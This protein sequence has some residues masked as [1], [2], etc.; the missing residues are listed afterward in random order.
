VRRLLLGDALP[1]HVAVVG[2]GD[3]GEDR[4][5]L[6]D[7]PHRH[8]VGRHTGAGGD[9]EETELGVDGIQ[10]TVGTEAHPGDVVAD[11]FGFPT[12]NGRLEHREVGLAALAREGAGDVVDLP[13]RG[14]QLEDEHVLGHPAVVAGH[15]R[16]DAQGVALLAEEGV[17]AVSA[18]VGPDFAGLGEVRDVLRFATGPLDVGLA[19]REW[20]A[21]GVQTLDE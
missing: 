10:P 20:E 13:L 15:G 12:G 7:R 3:I 11:H 9:A 1:P 5:A 6:L 2:A 21:D 14:G 17:A 19:I 18:S 4:V 8:G 16:G